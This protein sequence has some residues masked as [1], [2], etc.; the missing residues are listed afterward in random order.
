MF[1]EKCLLI[2]RLLLKLQIFVQV[3]VVQPHMLAILTRLELTA[4]LMI[5]VFIIARFQLRKF[6]RY[7]TQ[8][9]KL[10]PPVISPS[11]QSLTVR[12]F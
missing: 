12:R 8:L 1:Q 6:Q 11:P 10:M 2:Q 5:C 7:I 3:T 9:D 4:K